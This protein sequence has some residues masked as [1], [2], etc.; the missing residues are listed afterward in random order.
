MRI[1]FVMQLTENMS[2]S[3]KKKYAK[4]LKR[5]VFRSVLVDDMLISIDAV[6]IKIYHLTFQ[7]SFEN[8]RKIL[9]TVY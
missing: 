7:N 8:E 1:I 9:R 2:F 6:N 3:R 5:L 4:E